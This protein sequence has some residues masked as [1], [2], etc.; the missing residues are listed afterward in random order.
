MTLLCFLPKLAQILQ[1]VIVFFPERGDEIE[2][3]FW[4]ICITQWLKFF[5]ATVYLFRFRSSSVKNGWSK[6]DE[7][8]KLW[9]HLFFMETQILQSFTQTMFLFATVLPL[10]RVSAI[11]DH[12]WK[13]RARKPPKKGHLMDAKSARKTFY[14]N[15]R[16]CC[17]NETYDKYV[18][19]WECKPKTS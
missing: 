12:I 10:V 2:P 11:L 7:K 6:L 4:N 18:P 13:S 15:K 9:V 8:W 5:L 16:K 17:S 3:W 1:K 19:S 14:L